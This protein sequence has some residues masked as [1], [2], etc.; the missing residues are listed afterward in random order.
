MI[1]TTAATRIS[2]TYHY[3][4]L[5][6]FLPNTIDQELALELGPLLFDLDVVRGVLL[7]PVESGQRCDRF[8]NGDG[9]RKCIVRIDLSRGDRLRQLCP[10]R[11]SRQTTGATSRQVG[12]GPDAK[13]GLG[14]NLK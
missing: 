4:V 3:K 6:P 2:W 13:G 9:L 5:F 1:G 14:R 10:C 12:V 11:G 8:G 7:V